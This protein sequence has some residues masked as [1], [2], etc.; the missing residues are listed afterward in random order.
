MTFLG[1]NLLSRET[2]E[3]NI[4]H[5]KSS[6]RC[7]LNVL[8]CK[9]LPLFSVCVKQSWN[10]SQKPPVLLKNPDI[11]SC[12][13]LHAPHPCPL[14]SAF[15]AKTACKALLLYF[16]LIFLCST[17]SGLLIP[18]PEK[19]VE[20]YSCMCLVIYGIYTGGDMAPVITVINEITNLFS[21]T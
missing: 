20:I 10:F 16:T 18:T 15:I 12:E 21:C 9:H 5:P 3:S 19:S 6:P 8:M 13:Q 4:I 14:M 7:L 2:T 11:W 17:R 1:C